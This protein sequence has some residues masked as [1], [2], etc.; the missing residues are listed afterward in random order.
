[1]RPCLCLMGLL[2][3]TAR[4]S[5]DTYTVTHNGDGGPGSLRR[6]LKQAASHTGS[7]SVVFSAALLKQV[8]KPLTPLPEL[9]D[10]GTSIQGDIDADGTPDIALDGALAGLSHGLVVK[11]DKCTLSGLAIYRFQ[12]L[13]ISVQS[14]DFVTIR[15]CYL[16]V[17]LNGSTVLRNAG[18]EIYL[19][20]CNLGHVGSAAYAGPMV[21]AVP[22]ASSGRSAITLQHSKYIHVEHCNVGVAR[23]GKTALSEASV[24]G[25]GLTLSG[26]P[27]EATTSNIVV[28]GTTADHRNVFGGLKRAVDLTGAT[29]SKVWGNYFGLARNGNSP[30]QV[31]NGCLSLTGGSQGNDIGGQD[32]SQGN[33]ICGGTI[34]INISGEGTSG[35]RVLG[36]LFGL[37][38]A[39][40]VQRP[41]VIGVLVGLDCGVQQIGLVTGTPNYFCVQHSGD[42]VSNGVMVMYGGQGTNVQGN[43]FGRLPGGSLAVAYDNAVV[44]SSSY[45]LVAGNGFLRATTGLTCMATTSS[46]K[47]SFNT[48]KSCETAISLS[49]GA[50]INLGNVAGGSEYGGY[51]AFYTSNSTYVANR[52]DH[53]I[54]AE[55]NYFPFSDLGFIHLFIIDQKDNAAYGPVDIDPV[56]GLSP[57]LARTP[58][59]PTARLLA[60][61][62]LAA[63]AGARLSLTLS[64]AAR[65]SAEVTNLAGRP[66]RLLAADRLLPAGSG[67]LLWNGCN[68]RGLR[69]PAGTYLVRVR[70]CSEAGECSERVVRLPLRR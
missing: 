40:T 15:A 26:T 28:G 3:W 27:A 32:S 41:L 42:S 17:R 48:F 59:A 58:V 62:A 4:L 16:G 64:A 23:D 56:A 36:N 54:K 18:G 66:V 49:S 35:N 6:A 46:M 22:P 43:W 7:D 47:A 55:G 34:G 2:L 14:A 5:A 30:L 1:M 20:Y 24:A 39:G 63:A 69:V 60:A 21:I 8:I 33:V 9:T 29:D 53:T 68:D 25:T 61:S 67:S 44:Y 45:G 19:N 70:A 51:N 38:A 65:V 50:R 12:S 52:T 31:R 13:G 37:N 57:D 11:G 10:N